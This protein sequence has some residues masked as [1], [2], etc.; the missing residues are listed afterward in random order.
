MENTEFKV[1]D[2]VKLRTGL[3]INESIGTLVF[4]STMIFNTAVITKISLE[5]RTCTIDI[6]GYWYS[7]GMLELASYEEISLHTLLT[8]EIL[9]KINE[10]SDKFKWIAMDEN[11]NLLAYESKPKITIR[12]PNEYSIRNSGEDC[13]HLGKIDNSNELPEDYWKTT[14][15]EISNFKGTLNKENNMETEEEKSKIITEDNFFVYENIELISKII[16]SINFDDI[17]DTTETIAVDRCGAIYGYSEHQ[18]ICNSEHLGRAAN[19][20][21]NVCNIDLDNFWRQCIFSLTFILELKNRLERKGVEKPKEEK[22]DYDVSDRNFTVVNSEGDVLACNT[23]YFENNA[24]DL[25]SLFL[26]R[27]STYTHHLKNYNYIA[28]DLYGKVYVY[29]NAPKLGTSIWKTDGDYTGMLEMSEIS[30]DIFKQSLFTT[31]FILKQLTEFRSS[32]MECKTT[33]QSNSIKP[34][35][36]RQ[37]TIHDEICSDFIEKVTTVDLPLEKSNTKFFTL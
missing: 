5:D 1:G 3:E 31:A 11:G 36:E 19:K 32:P 22:N 7:F 6:N 25:Y 2:V 10:L 14:C 18:S 8:S 4:R 21:G 15:Q 27:I 29:A 13:K 17:R 9:E 20:L 23:R 33:N 26:E 12:F 34:E 30:E 35:Q 16:N 24:P 28:I 37:T